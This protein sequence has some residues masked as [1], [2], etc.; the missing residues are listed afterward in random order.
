MTASAR[1]LL[2]TAIFLGTAALM[3]L[4]SVSPVAAGGRFP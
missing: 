3:L 4:L 2:R 1:R